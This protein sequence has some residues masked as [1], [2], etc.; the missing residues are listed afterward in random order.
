LADFGDHAEETGW[1]ATIARTSRAVLLVDVVESVRL[2]EDDEIG[3]F[4]RWLAFVEHV[5]SG[6]TPSFSG[7]FIKS[8]GDGMLL[9]FANAKLAVAAAFAMQGE[10]QRI[11]RNYAP[12]KQILLRMGLEV[13]DVIHDQ[14]DIYGR[15][16]NLAARLLTLAGPTEIVISANIREQLTPDLDADVEDLGECYLKHV[17]HPVRAY[18][19]GPTGPHPVIDHGI[20]G[21]LA[22]SLAIVPFT[23]NDSRDEHHLL[24]EVL[25]EELICDLSR[26]P[27]LSVISRLST[28]RFRGREANLAEISTKLNACYVLSGEYRTHGERITADI[29]LADTRSGQIIWTRR[30]QGKITGIL[31]GRHGLTSK[32]A[33]EVNA[34]VMIREQQQ[35]RSQALPTL[36]SYTLLLGAIALMHRGSK[37]DFTEA[38]R[39]I[40][41][42]VERA[43]RHAIPR[44]WLAKWYV[45]RVQQGWSPDPKEDAGMALQCAKQ[46][47]D[48]DPHCSLALTMDGLVH[49]HFAKQLD[50][51]LARYDAAILTNPNDSLAWLLKGTL[52]A[53]R[54]DG[55]RAVSCTQRASRLSP[56]DPHKYYYDSLSASACVAAGRYEDALKLAQRSLRANRGHTSTLRVM[57]V[58]QWHLGCYYEARTTAQEL[59]QREPTLTV[60]RWLERAPSAP[61]KVGQEFAQVLR[62]VGVPD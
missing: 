38:R 54:G 57:A 21:D 40:D 52:H 3:F 59:L 18:R 20:L 24:G 60:S 4:S 47:L 22:P 49:T 7:R 56:L 32:I 51:A 45:L 41:T 5:K 46:A 53:F 26:S 11:N 13:G 39:L 16:V 58:A 25:A 14:N 37:E 35:A 34:A 1:F 44:A 30:H 48:A 2:V 12:D 29:E 33:A 6:I 23:T 62:L 10:S 15:S 8:T 50:T 42:L 27:E 36:K 31:S 28:T 17:P 43:S 19:V 9:D 61:F 55:E